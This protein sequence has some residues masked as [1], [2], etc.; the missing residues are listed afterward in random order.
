MGAKQMKRRKNKHIFLF[1]V[2]LLCIGMIITGFSGCRKGPQS[3]RQLTVFVPQHWMQSAIEIPLDR[4]RSERPEVTVEIYPLPD[5]SALNGATTLEELL[6]AQNSYNAELQQ[7]YQK[8]QAELL[9][10]KGPDLIIYDDQVFQDPQKVLQSGKFLDLKP[11]LE[12]D[13]GYDPARY[14]AVVRSAGEYR[15]GL[16]AFPLA[17]RIGTMIST[18]EALA[19][20][21]FDPSKTSD[22]VGQLAEGARVAGQPNAPRIFGARNLSTDPTMEITDYLSYSGLH[23][24]DYNTGTLQIDTEE[25]RAVQEEVKAILQ[26]D[27]KELEVPA[28]VF[29]AAHFERDRILRRELLWALPTHEFGTAAG[30]LAP[31]ETPIVLP[32]PAVDGGV[33]ANVSY[34][35]AISAQSE[36]QENAYSLLKLLIGDIFQSQLIGADFPILTSVNE[37]AVN[38]W[39]NSAGEAEAG[40]PEEIYDEALH[41]NERITSVNFYGKTLRDMVNELF[42][43]YYEGKASYEECLGKAKAQLAIYISE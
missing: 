22:Y 28:D 17:Y 4:F 10:G 6:A 21:G 20:C 7:T 14:N 25:F 26:A 12:A 1:L 32:I 35:A 37:V 29:T 41:W 33:Q 30:G 34:F 27:R 31:K 19:D 2:G 39:K 40:L 16:Y 43:P 13:S 18:E 15:D 8:L 3:S 5:E 36:N 9:A 23:L 42:Q 24:F 38:R 11:L